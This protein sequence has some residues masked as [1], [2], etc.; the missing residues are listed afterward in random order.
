MVIQLYMSEFYPCIHSDY[1]LL[2][3]TTA[4]MK[5]SK[6]QQRTE[7]EKRYDQMV[8]VQKIIKKYSNYEE[9]QRLMRLKM[10]DTVGEEIELPQDEEDVDLDAVQ[11]TAAD[12][13][14][15]PFCYTLDSNDE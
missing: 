3:D 14:M 1:Q 9:A 12:I 10:L 8:M 13:I 4:A 15:N 2:Y 11:I 6:D 7:K 5:I